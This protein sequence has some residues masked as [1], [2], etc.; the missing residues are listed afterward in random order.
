MSD[1]INTTLPSGKITSANSPWQAEVELQV[2][3]YDVDPMEVVW[4]GRYI[5]YFEVARSA[6]L[7]QIDYNYSAMKDSGYLWPIVD[8]QVRYSRPAIFRQRLKVRAA[9]IEWENRLKIEYLVIDAVSGQ[10]LTR[11]VTVQVAVQAGN[12]TLSFISPPA[13]WQRLGL[14]YPIP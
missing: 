9:I 5:E 11:G 2:Q 4:H 8:L 6:L 1:T 12:S 14:T 3:F 7:D 10:R 13:L